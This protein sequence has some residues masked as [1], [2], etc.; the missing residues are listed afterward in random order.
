MRLYESWKETEKVEFKK[1]NFELKE[2]IISL[3]AMLNKCGEGT[4]FYGV[5]K[6]GEVIGQQVGKDT[7]RTILEAVYN[8]IE[9]TIIHSIEVRAADN[10]REYIKVNV[11][12][13]DSSYS[14]LSF[15]FK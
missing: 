13:N 11:K 8:A 1:I 7:E 15:I 3:S 12:G 5:R 10:G 14:A 4:L 2:G 9:P 6:D